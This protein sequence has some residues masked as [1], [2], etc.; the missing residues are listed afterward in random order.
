MSK[1]K[2]KRGTTSPGT[3]L[4]QGEPGF[5][6]TEKTLYIGNGVGSAPTVVTVK[7]IRLV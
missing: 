4:E 6:T 2:I 1:L 5:D 3:T 7:I